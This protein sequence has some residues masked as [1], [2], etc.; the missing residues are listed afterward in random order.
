MYIDLPNPRPLSN[1]VNLEKVWYSESAEAPTP[2]ANSAVPQA[3]TVPVAAPQVPAAPVQMPGQVTTTATAQIATPNNVAQQIIQANQQP[4]ELAQPQVV[5][6]TAE[7]QA[8]NPM[9]LTPVG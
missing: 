2:Q 7:T 4:Q 6:N 8:V 3:A 9:M 5:Q 1:N